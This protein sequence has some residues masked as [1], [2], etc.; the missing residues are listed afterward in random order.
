MN[1]VSDVIFGVFTLAIIIA[2]WSIW[3]SLKKEIER[4]HQNILKTIDNMAREIAANSV[5]TED[6]VNELKLIALVS[7]G[8]IEVLTNHSPAKVQKVIEELYGDKEDA[9]TNILEKWIKE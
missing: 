5:D 2:I 7:S 3:Q 6:V 4:K 8:E 1:Y 9:I